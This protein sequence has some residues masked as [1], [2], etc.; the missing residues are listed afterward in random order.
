MVKIFRNFKKTTAFKVDFGA[1]GDLYSL[2]S[3]FWV[4]FS[5][6]DTNM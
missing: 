6:A 4:C 3:A 5:L 2:F 1:E